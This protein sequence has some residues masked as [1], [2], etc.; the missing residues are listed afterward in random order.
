[1][2]RDFEIKVN[3]VNKK[4]L[5]YSERINKLIV[6]MTLENLEEFM[7]KEFVTINRSSL[8][9]NIR[10]LNALLEHN[11]SEIRIE[12]S[13]YVDELVKIKDEQYYSLDE[14]QE[15]C[16]MLVNAQD[17]FILY[18]LWSGIMGKGYKDLVNIKTKDIAEDNGYIMINGS[19]FICDDYMKRILRSCKRQR[20]YS[21]YI[22]SNNS[23]QN[24][25]FDFNMKS[26]YLLKVSPTIKNND[27]KNPM[28]Q[29]TVQRRLITLEKEYREYT[30]NDYIQL[31]G[32][33]L[34]K[35]GIM[36]DMFVKEMKE[37]V[38]WDGEKIDNYLKMNG[39]PGNFAQLYRCYHNKYHGANTN[40]F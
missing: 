35:S 8:Y 16:E 33:S 2:S 22:K 39:I 31:N 13:D 29:S 15:V 5:K 7:K 37:T 34:V 23:I 19:K 9:Q 24:T 36:F 4:L 21:K 1:M 3:R 11:K 20:S 6:D 40:V 12:S 38:S 18:A 17:K 26:E 32:L 30:K 28:K 10:C 25:E 27:G 14:I